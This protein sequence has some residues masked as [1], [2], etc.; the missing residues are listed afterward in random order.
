MEQLTCSLLC[1]CAVGV[2]SCL[3][4]GHIGI[5]VPDVNA[6]CQLFE[7]Q[8]VKFLKNPASGEF[9]KTIIKLS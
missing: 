4:A 7:K 8:G 5:A 2:T 1:V 6:A 3:V 9:E